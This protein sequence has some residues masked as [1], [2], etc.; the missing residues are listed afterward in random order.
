MRYVSTLA[1]ERNSGSKYSHGQRS[2]EATKPL[3]ASGAG[4]K[5]WLEMG[6]C[7]V[8][9]LLAAS[10]RE[11]HLARPRAMLHWRS[12]T[13]TINDAFLRPFKAVAALARGAMA[14]HTTD[15]LASLAT[16]MAPTAPSAALLQRASETDV[17]LLL[18]MARD[19]AVPAD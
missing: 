9:A 7:V 13:S 18:M 16:A 19:A 6:R 12:L 2:S 8:D 17:P 15:G 3:Q 11:P 10:A 1:H 4:R 5:G 14:D